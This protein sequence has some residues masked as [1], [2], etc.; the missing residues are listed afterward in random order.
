MSTAQTVQPTTRRS[1][2]WQFIVKV[3]VGILISLVLVYIALSAYAGYTLSTSKRIFEPKKS[4]AFAVPLE[5]V[6]I[7]AADGLVIAGW[8]IPSTAGD[9][10]ALSSTNYTLASMRGYVEKCPRQ[11]MAEGRCD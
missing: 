10:I 8:F 11:I 7:P 9:N 3:T 1:F 6:K 5:D 2:R 4:A